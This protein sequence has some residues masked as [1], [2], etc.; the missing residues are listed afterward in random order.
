MPLC[1]Y[2]I[3]EYPATENFMKLLTSLLLIILFTACSG[4]SPQSA[5]LLHNAVIY[6]VNPE[7]PNADAMAFDGDGMI[8]ALGGSTQLREQFKIIDA[9]DARGKTVVRRVG[10]MTG[11]F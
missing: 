6:T 9:I 8:L 5:V 10:G 7:Q 11:G 2:K 4:Q 3:D 1:V